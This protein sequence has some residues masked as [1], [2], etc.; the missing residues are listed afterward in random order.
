MTPLGQLILEAL[1]ETGGATG[2]DLHEDL[3][4]TIQELLRTG[5]LRRKGKKLCCAKPSAR[6]RQ[7]RAVDVARSLRSSSDV[8]T[9]RLGELIALRALRS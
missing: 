9:R 7:L 2:H 3:S 1:A 4:W 6:R 5:A 8:F